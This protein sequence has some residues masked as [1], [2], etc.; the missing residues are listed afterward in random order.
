MW[1]E[2]NF[3]FILFLWKKSYTVFQVLSFTFYVVSEQPFSNNIGRIMMG[4]ELMPYLSGQGAVYVYKT[5]NFW[6]VLKS[7]G[8]DKFK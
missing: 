5:N 7:A 3:K 8:Y 2:I 1:N 6:T 4:E